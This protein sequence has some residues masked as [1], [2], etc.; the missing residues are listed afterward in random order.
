[1][2][3]C[4]HDPLGSAAGDRKVMS[5]NSHGGL[6]S[7]SLDRWGQAMFLHG[8]SIRDRIVKQGIS[9]RCPSLGTAY[10]HIHVPVFLCFGW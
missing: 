6:L 2:A 10:Q 1:M 5:S 4:L 8:P 9:I 3:V 7:S